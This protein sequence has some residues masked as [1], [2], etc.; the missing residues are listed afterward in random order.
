V[1]ARA[2]KQEELQGGGKSGSL[3]APFSSSFSIFCTPSI[4]LGL[5]KQW[6]QLHQLS[7]LQFHF[8]MQQQGFNVVKLKQENYR[9]KSCQ[10]HGLRF[11]H[12]LVYLCCKG[13]VLCLKDEGIEG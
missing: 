3:K 8:N 10:Q 6:Y 12:L 1:A 7:F 9:Q 11:H 5:G 4:L 13:C 2:R